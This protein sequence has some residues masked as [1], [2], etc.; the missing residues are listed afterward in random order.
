M[1]RIIALTRL[2]LCFASSPLLAQPSTG[3]PLSRDAI[4]D[5]MRRACDYQLDQQAKTKFDNGWIRGAFYTG[6]MAAHRAT[7]DA[8][9]LDAATTWSEAAHYTPTTRKKRAD[10]QCCGQTYL[11]LY[12]LKHDP[13]MLAPI[14]E[15]IDK[16][17][18]EGK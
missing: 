2:V 17:L 18:G 8:K 5:V 7:G 16:M 15:S 1:I 14:K 3:D 9:Y 6:V 4:L 10:D 13:Q 12:L 11:E